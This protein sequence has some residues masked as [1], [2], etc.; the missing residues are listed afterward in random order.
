M[1]VNSQSGRARSK[2]GRRDRLQ[3][4]EQ[5][6]LGSRRGQAH[7]PQ[8]EVEVERR[9]DRPARRA[10]PERRRQ[11]ALAQPRD[12]A[13]RPVDAVAQPVEVG[14]RSKIATATIVERRIGSFST[15]H[16]SASSSL[17]CVVKR[18]HSAIARSVAV[19]DAALIERPLP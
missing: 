14:G 1:S 8:M 13:R 6:A 9:L 16:M 11:H 19:E 3:H 15:F 4:V 17:M 5:R 2:L 12:E 7:A 10:E 18:G